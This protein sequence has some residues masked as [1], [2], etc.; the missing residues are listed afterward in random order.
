[1]GEEKTG[2]SHWGRR[3]LFHPETARQRPGADSAQGLR[4]A[5]RAWA[6]GPQAS[7]RGASS[8]A[9][10]ARLGR[11]WASAP[12]A[13]ARD[14][15]ASQ[16]THRPARRFY[17]EA[18][19]ARRTRSSPR[20]A[21]AQAARR[22]QRVV[23][24]PIVSR[25]VRVGGGPTASR[26]VPAELSAPARSGPAVGA[27]RWSGPDVLL[28]PDPAVSSVREPRERNPRA[29]S[30]APAPPSSAGS[31]VPSVPFSFRSARRRGS[32]VGDR[33]LDRGRPPCRGRARGVGPSGATGL[34]QG[35][36][37]GW[38]PPKK[39]PPRL[40]HPIPWPGARS[41]SLGSPGTAWCSALS[42]RRSQT[43][44]AAGFPRRARHPSGPGPAPPEPPRRTSAG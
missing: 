13:A 10:A 19:R 41:P 20:P 4:G 18:M 9:C 38:S 3:L 24:P 29:A 12:G 17:S 23:S 32:H 40:S 25:G 26:R 22:A 35:A 21:P 5:P 11:G 27:V 15:R 42:P 34:P 36:R 33:R 28:A 44:G 16:V 37:E 6:A 7:P 39:S 1:M 43:P 2:R 30:P 8:E 14:L 31:P